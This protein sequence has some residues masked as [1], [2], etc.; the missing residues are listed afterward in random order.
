MKEVLK[1]IKKMVMEFTRRKETFIREILSMIKDKDM[2]K[3]LFKMEMYT[4]DKCGIIL[5]RVMEYIIH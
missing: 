3:L 4:L 5:L 1:T 2:E